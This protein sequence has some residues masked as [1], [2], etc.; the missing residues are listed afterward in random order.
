MSQKYKEWVFLL[1]QRKLLINECESDVTNTTGYSL[2]S[3]RNIQ[4]KT[5]KDITCT[6][7]FE[8]MFREKD[9]DSL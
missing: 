3:I 9:T 1:H 2:S 6:C 7:V 5:P 4:I 8:T